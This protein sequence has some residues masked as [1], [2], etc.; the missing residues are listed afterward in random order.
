M[1]MNGTS[2]VKKDTHALVEGAGKNLYFVF[3]VSAASGHMYSSF[4]HYLAS[5]S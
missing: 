3:V 4:L 2:P 1:M 5:C